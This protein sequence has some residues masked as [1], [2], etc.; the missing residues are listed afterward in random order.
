LPRPNPAD[1]LH[2]TVATNPYLKRLAASPFSQPTPRLGGDTFREGANA[3]LLATEPQDP[4]TITRMI[5]FELAAIADCT[6]DTWRKELRQISLAAAAHG[7]FKS[8]VEGF[9]DIG[10]HLGALA[11]KPAEQH[12]HLH[13]A[14]SVKE[15]TTSELEAKLAALRQRQ[16]EAAAQRKAHEAQTAAEDLL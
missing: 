4:V 5:L 7:D 16:A 3:I 2:G 10:K 13:D 6:L 11:E 9:R 12:L 15:A 8:A 14:A 1:K